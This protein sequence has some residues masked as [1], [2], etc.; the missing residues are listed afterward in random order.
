M[1]VLPPEIWIDSPLYRG[2]Q[3]SSHGRIRVLPRIGLMPHGGKRTYETKPTFGCITSAKKGARHVYFGR[4]IKA[5]GN[6]K[7]HRAVCSAFHGKPPFPKAVV[8]HRNENGLDNRPPNVRWGTQKENLNMPR[9]KDCNTRAN[10]V[11]VRK[12]LKDA[13]KTADIYCGLQ[14]LLQVLDERSKKAA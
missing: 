4:Q 12:G 3:A 1:E 8:I 14:Q 9:F 13:P 10:K 5:I 2:V 7:V 6:V 11:A